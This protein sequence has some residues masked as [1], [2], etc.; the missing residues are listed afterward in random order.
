MEYLSE[1]KDHYNKELLSILGKPR[2]CNKREIEIL[3]KV[4]G[5][6]LPAAY[7]EYLHWMGKS[8]DGVL[9][10]TNCFIDDIEGNNKSLPYVFE[11]NEVE[12]E[13]KNYLAFY[14][15]QGYVYVW[16]NLP[17][18]EDDPECFYINEA[19]RIS[20]VNSAGKFSEFITSEV[21]NMGRLAK[22]N[23]QAKKWWQFWRE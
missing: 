5:F 23:K 22:E 7:R 12:Y 17:A 4:L 21:I 2:G 19:N 9:V 13:L 14:N 15:H 10:G 11:D 18:E 8:D 1:L 6:S 16:F 3:E 20:Q